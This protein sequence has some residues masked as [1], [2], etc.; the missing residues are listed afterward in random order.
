MGEMT[1]RERE[2]EKELRVDGESGPSDRLEKENE[3]L[4]VQDDV[5]KVDVLD[6]YTIQRGMELIY[7]SNIKPLLDDL[8]SN[9]YGRSTIK[10]M[11]SY[12]AIVHFA[13]RKSTNPSEGV[14]SLMGLY[15]N[16]IKDFCRGMRERL[17]RWTGPGASHALVAACM[18][19][20]EK[21]TALVYEMLKLFSYLDG[22]K[23]KTEKSSLFHVAMVL[24]KTKLYDHLK[25]N[26]REALIT[27]INIERDGGKVFPMMIKTVI[28]IFKTMGDPEVSVKRHNTKDNSYL[29][30]INKEKGLSFCD[31]EE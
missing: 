20:W 24:F 26:L 27:E 30:W 16:T 15:K 12:S 6:E 1:E 8:E 21:F 11:N 23:N 10:F 19:E 7:T 14:D 13:Q 5:L 17:S 4:R 9:K 31:F 28:N 22:C 25:V 18:D 29:E 3:G 2:L